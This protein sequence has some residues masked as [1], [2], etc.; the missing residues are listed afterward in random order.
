VSIIGIDQSISCT[1]I[2]VLDELGTVLKSFTKSFSKLEAGHRLIGYYD[3]FY[4]LIPEYPDCTWALEGYS[5]GSKFRREQLGELRG[6]IELAFLHRGIK[7]LII[8][9][10][11]H[12][13]MMTSKGNANKKALKETIIKKYGLKFKTQDEYDAYSISMCL[14]ELVKSKVYCLS[15]QKDFSKNFENFLK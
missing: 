14:N 10:T 3:F 7:P 5:Y 12:K 8:P 15:D 2:V 11:V 4:N 9:I 13:K 6:I 1:A